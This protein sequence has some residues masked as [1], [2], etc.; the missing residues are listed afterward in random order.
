MGGSAAGSVTTPIVRDENGAYRLQVP[1]G[2]YGISFINQWDTDELC[3]IQYL[4]GEADLDVPLP[5]IVTA[6]QT[7]TVNATFEPKPVYR[8]QGHVTDSTGAPVAGADVEAQGFP[9]VCAQTRTA[10]DGSYGFDANRIFEADLF[11]R[12]TSPRLPKVYFFGGT[13]LGNSSFSLTR[14]PVQT[15]DIVVPTLDSLGTVKVRQRRLDESRYPLVSVTLLRRDEAEWTR[16]NESHTSRYGNAALLATPGTYRIRY[17]PTDRPFA[18]TDLYA[19]EVCETSGASEYPLRSGGEV[20]LDTMISPTQMCALAN[21]PITGSSRVSAVLRV[22]DPPWSAPPRARAYRWYRDSTPIR[23]A[24]YPTYRVSASDAGHRLYVRIK[25][26]NARA[27]TG[28]T[29]SPTTSL[30]RR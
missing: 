13:F 28:T 22:A 21:P 14:E 23:G 3:D 29:V 24:I 20:F 8:V 6:G 18:R 15:V 12:P 30:I 10:T 9:G 25:A 4:E 11:V 5:V 16:M 1:P 26:N 27:G 17:A 7:T 19:R 2:V